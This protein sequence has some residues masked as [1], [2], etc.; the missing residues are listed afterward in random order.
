MPRLGVLSI[1]VR[2]T[3]AKEKR[4]VSNI[5]KIAKVASSVYTLARLGGMLVPL[6]MKAASD[7]KI[8]GMEIAEMIE[9]AARVLDISFD[10]DWADGWDDEAGAYGGGEGV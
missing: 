4:E 1:T 10:V 9:S 3:A 5:S 7:G 6:F 8:T 2:G